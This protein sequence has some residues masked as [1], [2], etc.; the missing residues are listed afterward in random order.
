ME[1][2]MSEDDAVL[3]TAATLLAHTLGTEREATAREVEQAVTLALRNGEKLLKELNKQRDEQ[4]KKAG[5]QGWLQQ[6]SK[7]HAEQTEKH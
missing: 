2:L 6:G 3:L 4:A 1:A 5:E 7:Q